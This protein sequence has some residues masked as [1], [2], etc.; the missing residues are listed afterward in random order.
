[1]EQQKIN[2]ALD[3]PA[4]AGKS[5]IAKQLAQKLDILYLDTGAMYRALGLKAKKCGVDPKDRA[6]V[7]ALLP[8]TRVDVIYQNGQMRVELDGENVEPAIRT[9]EMGMYASAVAAHPGVREYLVEL[10]RKIALEN[11]LVL[12]GRDIGTCVLPDTRYKFFITASL[13][14]RAHRRFAELV[15]KGEKSESFE[16]V[17]AAMAQ[18]DKADAERE[19]SPL[20]CADDAEVVDTTEMDIDEVVDFLIEAIDTRRHQA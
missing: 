18:R 7:E 10:Q 20:T 9:Q 2:I 19:F 4:G 6:K 3:G 17:K 14:E 16:A 12:D 15:Q 13:E 1:M 11:D 8:D 5:T